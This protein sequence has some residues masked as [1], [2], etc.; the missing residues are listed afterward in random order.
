MTP[1][2]LVPCAGRSL[3]WRTTAFAAKRGAGLLAT[4]LAIAVLAPDALAAGF[5]TKTA[6]AA[7]TACQNDVRN[8]FWV[9]KGICINESDDKDRR[10]CNDGAQTE[11]EDGLRLCRQKHNAR[12]HVCTI[13]GE[14]RYD[15]EF[16]PAQFVNPDNIGHGIAPNPYFPLVRGMRFTYKGGG[17][18]IT[19]TVTDKTK[20]IDGVTCRVVEDVVKEH[21]VVVE[22]TDDWFAQDLAGNVWYCGELARVFETFKGDRP[23]D[24]ELTSIEGS[25]KAEREGD[26]PGIIA[27]VAP[28]VGDGY[29]EEFSLANAEDVAEVISTTGSAAVP[30]AMCNKTCLVTRNTSPLEPGIKETK[31]YAPG[32]GLILEVENDGTRVELV[33]VTH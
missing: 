30:A 8:T 13:V 3:G 17:Q 32:V 18:V 33:Q 9:T 2:K 12:L 5:C 23:Q 15:P 28:Q 21:G 31:Y 22:R 6:D 29:Y 10:T 7:L 14:D 16:E 26:K 27:L 4:G 11:M 1:H 19:D 24:P 20:H 25:F